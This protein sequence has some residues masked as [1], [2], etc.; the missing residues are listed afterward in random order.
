MSVQ[1]LGWVL[2]NSTTRGTDRLVL[3]ALAN[4]AGELTKDGTFDAWPGVERIAREAG[5]DRPRTAQQA[6]AR[7]VA[8][9]AIERV[10][11]GAPDS[12]IR[13][14]RRPNLYRII[15]QAATSAGSDG[16]DD[17]SASPAAPA[18][19]PMTG[20]AGASP[21]EAVD[22]SRIEANGVSPG[23]TP[24]SPRGDAPESHGV[25]PGDTRTVIEP[26]V[27]KSSVFS[28]S[29]GDRRTDDDDGDQRH[30]VEAVHR[31]LLVLA[32]RDLEERNRAVPNDPIRTRHRRKRW[33]RTGYAT[34]LDADAD[35]LVVLHE[36]RPEL[37]PEQLADLVLGGDAQAVPARADVHDLGA[38][39]E[40]RRPDA[41]DG[42]QA[43]LRRR[44]AE[45]ERRRRDQGD[46]EVAAPD[47]AS[48]H[49]SAARA[50]LGPLAASG[51]MGSDRRGGSNAG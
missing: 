29:R 17:A 3:I 46:V 40:R 41:R 15:T 31:A 44:I 51:A 49:L 47:V 28:R 18:D 21:R 25:S 13:K 50:A 34:R 2:E 9:G 12:R 39:R 35:A 30:P 32:G 45:D 33:M 27:P 5:L 14:D 38:E 36:A 1:A 8:A 48:G 4:H 26:D 23:V 37:M 11:N 10:L 42:Q 22:N 19:G 7:L 24:Q 43:A 20:C 16:G 6:L